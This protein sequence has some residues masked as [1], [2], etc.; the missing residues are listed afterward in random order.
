MTLW[1]V[2]A[3]KGGA[4]STI[5]YDHNVVTIGW[6]ELPDLSKFEDKRQLTEYYLRTYSNQKPKSAQVGIGQIWNFVHDIKKGDLVALPLPS[7]SS[8]AIG[9][10]VGN[11]EYRE[12]AQEIKHIRK[13]RWL[14]KLPR[15]SFDSDIL[16]SFGAIQTVCRIKRNDA[17]NRVRKMAHR[18]T[19]TESTLKTLTTRTEEEEFDIEQF[20]KD[21]MIKYITANFSG[22]ALALLVEAILKAQGFVTERSSPGKDGGVDILAGSGSLGLNEPRLCVQVK[23]SASQIGVDVLRQL[24]GTMQNFKAEKGLLIAWGG[25]TRDA[26]QEAKQSYF[27][28]RLWNQGE[29]IDEITRQYDK[30]DDELKAELP[31]KRIW[32]LV[33]EERT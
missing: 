16:F 15:S 6:N 29:L 11:Y 17:E 18:L 12:I 20:A 7:E 4:Q 14:S 25:Y 13:V 26:L 19:G 1:Q 8:I 24:Q 22:H 10:I 27:S 33:D 9:E 28:I 31:L 5:A 2:R 3:G 21:E 32:V 23:S 30:F